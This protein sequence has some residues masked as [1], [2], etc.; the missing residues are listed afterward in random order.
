M[1]KPLTK[2][3]VNYAMN[4][5]RLNSNDILILGCLTMGD[6][7]K[8][9]FDILYKALDPEKRERSFKALFNVLKNTP[10]DW[11]C[12]VAVYYSNGSMM[13]EYTVEK[14]TYPNIIMDVRNKAFESLKRAVDLYDADESRTN[15][16]YTYTFAITP[17]LGNSPKHHSVL[18]KNFVVD[19]NILNV[20]RNVLAMRK[21]MAEKERGDYV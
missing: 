18:K 14:N 21:L 6:K 7:V 13:A 5:Y 20:E 8:D 9:N 2:F 19:N 16:P 3:E 12:E 17:Y 1:E 15:I 4:N 10:N 11:E